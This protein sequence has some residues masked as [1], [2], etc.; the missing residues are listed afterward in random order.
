MQTG[1]KNKTD[2]DD[3]KSIIGV[4]LVTDVGRTK[5]TNL[6][7]CLIQSQQLNFCNVVELRKAIRNDVIACPPEFQICTKEG[8]PLRDIQEQQLFVHQILNDKQEVLIKVKHDKPKCGIKDQHGYVIGFVHISYTD[9]L[10][11]LKN[12]VQSQI[13]KPDDISKDFKFLD[14]NS[15]PVSHVQEHHMTV[16]D[17]L[18]G[19]CVSTNIQGA[20]QS[21]IFSPPKEPPLKKLKGVKELSFRS[22]KDLFRQLDSDVTDSGAKP[23]QVLISYVR[24]EAAN[25]ALKLKERLTSLG[26]SV[27]LDVH[28]IQT[29]VDWQDSLNFAVSGC[30]VFVPLVTLKYGETQWTNREVKLADVL[31]KYILPVNFLSDWPPRCLAIQFATTQFIPWVPPEDLPARSQT[32]IEK[33]EWSLHD[34]QL[35]A[36]K[37][38]ERVRELS[39]K[40]VPSLIKRTTIVKSCACVTED[41]T[42][43]ITSD[44]DG[45]PLV[46]IC[47]HHTQE[48]Y[49]AELQ[50]LLEE[51]GFEVWCT[52]ELDREHVEHIDGLA[53]SQDDITYSILNK[54]D[55]E[56]LGCPRN[57]IVR[58]IE[59][60]QE[61]ADDASLVL[62]ILSDAFTNS[63]VC[64][65][66]VFYCE[67]RKHVIPILYED[68]KMPDCM[69]M[70]IGSHG[71]MMKKDE[72]FV[73]ML[74]RTIKATISSIRNS[75]SPRSA[76]NTGMRKRT[77]SILGTM[78]TNNVPRDE[79]SLS[80]IQSM[81]VTMQTKSV[82]GN[83][84][85]QTGTQSMQGT[86]EINAVSSDGTSLPVFSNGTEAIKR[87][88]D[89]LSV[90]RSC[91]TV[92]DSLNGDHE[93]DMLT[94]VND[95]VNEEINMTEIAESE[96]IETN[97]G[98]L[99]ERPSLTSMKTIIL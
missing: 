67:H 63:R 99:D 50:S 72:D 27:Y 5:T 34:I 4:G 62:F 59:I 19:Y 98:R 78:K 58:N 51:E 52:T 39:L 46:M 93:S 94:N 68:V 61:K 84:T 1:G 97:I 90:N 24:S 64:Q 44:R 47:V 29:G 75:V 73:E 91:R 53:S 22:S 92:H 88:I 17:I 40:A 49:G 25:H 6:G 85:S 10:A 28:E 12:L 16:S 13:L 57:S 20:S 38:A 42:L 76:A 3:L 65:Q 82:P 8:W 77:H 15:W 70:L 11:A 80:G 31:G 81:Q 14:G 86:M 37:I 79:T 74:I 55:D 2:C 30:E 32:S 21:K 48:T 95:S 66:Q 89:G 36:Q 71:F 69:S 26:L 41:N 33:Y 9:V 35:V 96:I 83:G 18:I 7:V 43:A 23:K 87:N 45:K 54:G 60:F 56:I